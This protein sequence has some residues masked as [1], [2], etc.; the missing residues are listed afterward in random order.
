MGVY[1]M[2]GKSNEVDNVGIIECQHN[3]GIEAAYH[4]VA[5]SEANFNTIMQAVGVAELRVYEE[6][7]VEMV[8]EAADVKGFFGKV[9]EFFVNLWEKIKGLFKKFFAMFDSLVK[10]DKDFVNKYKGSITQASTTGFK[11]KG[12][13]FTLDAVSVSGADSKI[14]GVVSGLIGSI[15]DSADSL[16]AKIKEASDRS[17]LV[18]KM[19]G[20]AIGES[21]LSAAELSKEIYA[22]LRSGESTKEEIDNV[23]TTTLMQDIL[24][25]SDLKK[26][27]EKQYSDLE[28]IIKDAI[29][30]TEKTQSELLKGIPSGDSADTTLRALKVKYASNK[31]SLLKE[32]MA[33]LQ[34]VNG[35]K[36]TAIKDRNR[37]SKAI[38]VALMSHKPKNESTTVAESG[39]LAN[40][41]IR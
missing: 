40:V 39:F 20:A 17:E 23:N 41:T 37:Q 34:V 4:I 19:R 35:A 1:T 2:S 30:E 36:L 26:A 28:K 9:K 22:K 14:E 31:V 29:K 32:K 10:S 8:Y 11:Y 16:E 6:S 5:E 38:C 21:S 7:G 12:F 25:T 18:E 24:G 33:V 27:A 3:P 15:P 13:N